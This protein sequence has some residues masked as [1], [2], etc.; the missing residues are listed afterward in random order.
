MLSLVTLLN[1]LDYGCTTLSGAPG[2][3]S[4]LNA[5]ARL[6]CH[7]IMSP[8]CSLTCTGCR[9][10]REYISDWPCLSSAVVT[11]WR[12][13]TSPVT[14][15]G[16]A[17]RKR[18]KDCVPALANDWLCRELDFALW[19]PIFVRGTAPT[20]VRQFV[21]ATYYQLLSKVWLS[22]VCWSPSAK[23]DNEAECRIYWGLSLIHIWRCR[24]RG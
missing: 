23:P 12:L 24:R 19:P 4:V 21:R 11:T 18:C 9:F 5:V 6:V 7:T 10:R 15:A 20:F 8:I 22:S 1:R 14:C 17:R 13:C 2:H 16:P 3:Q